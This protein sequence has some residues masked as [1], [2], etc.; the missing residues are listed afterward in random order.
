MTLPKLPRPAAAA[1]LATILFGLAPAANADVPSPPNATVPACIAV[2]GHDAGGVLDPLSQFTVTLR[3]LANNPVAGAMIV[4]DF[5]AV[6]ELRLCA[7]DHDVNLI[8]DCG[9]RTVRRTTD[10]NGIATFRIA[11]WSIATPGAPGAPY[12]GGKIYADGVLLGSPTIQIYDLNPNGLSAADL[13]SWLGDFFSGNDPARGDYD[14]SGA[15]GASDFSMWLTAYFAGGSPAN[16]S[17]GGP[18]P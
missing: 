10:V 2:M 11:G 12:H 15:L 1:C 9:T 6:S 13:S 8:V 18:C 4:V 3:D 5:G 14:C 7:N 17:P 16:C